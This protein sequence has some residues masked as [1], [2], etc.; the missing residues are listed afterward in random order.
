[1]KYIFISPHFDDICFSMGGFLQN[2]GN[3]DK[4]VINVFTKTPYIRRLSMVNRDIN[5]KTDIVSRIRLE[6]DLEFCQLYNIRQVNLDFYESTEDKDLINHEIYRQI[7]D[8]VEFNS[9]C[10]VFFPMGIGRHR[11]H[12]QIFNICKRIINNY[13]CNF[14]IYEDLPYAH[15]RFNRYDRI[16]EISNFLIENGFKNY[17][18]KLSKS[19]IQQKKKDIMIYESQHTYKNFNRV[20][21]SRYYTRITFL[22]LAREGFWF[23]SIGGELNSFLENLK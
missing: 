3:G 23:R 19:S 13:N 8:N 10:H 2:L 17:L 7:C 12:I 9:D 11:N 1:M 4:T 18:Y 21:I 16:G 14:I 22:P 15:N 6:E 5:F 20:K